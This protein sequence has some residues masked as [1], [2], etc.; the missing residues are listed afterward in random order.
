MTFVRKYRIVYRVCDPQIFQ[1]NYMSYELHSTTHDFLATQRA[2]K[3]TYTVGVK[4]V[5]II[6]HPT[7][8]SPLYDWA[9][10][11]MIE[12]LPDMKGKSWLEI[13]PGTGL[14]TVFAAING[15]KHITA[16]DINPYAVETTIKNLE[17]NKHLYPDTCWN[18]FE[19]DVFEKVS[20]RFDV[21]T[22][23]LPYHGSKPTDLLE[24]A[25]ADEG[26]QG[27][28]KFFTAITDHLAPNGVV[29][30]GTSESADLPRVVDLIFQ[31]GLTI[32]KWHS[33]W[34]AGYNCITLECRRKNDFDRSSSEE[35]RR[36][37]SNRKVFLK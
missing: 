27:A 6:V 2:H 3:E 1:E 29:L 30:V 5:P 18:I 32:C 25:V 8:I 22:W 9:G 33:D 17:V 10:E 35:Y 20:G 16:C 37:V 12:C 31:A 4:N 34:R 28:E 19:S 14:V 15:A 21:V 11:Y 23:N 36:W 26:Y 7:T 13:G 24:R